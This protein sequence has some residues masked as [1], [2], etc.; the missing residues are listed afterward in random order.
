MRMLCNGISS[1]SC[2][3]CKMTSGIRPRGL[4]ASLKTRPKMFTLC[5][6]SIRYPYTNPQQENNII[7]AKVMLMPV[8]DML[9]EYAMLR[10]FCINLNCP[11]SLLSELSGISWPLKANMS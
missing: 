4:G 11:S 8:A 6:A 9:Y 2:V 1:A 10:D 3:G 7:I 5:P